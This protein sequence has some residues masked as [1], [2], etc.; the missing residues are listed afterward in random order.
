MIL[1]I[2]VGERQQHQNWFLL[3]FRSRLTFCLSCLKQ[4]S[5]YFFATGRKF[6][7]AF[8]VMFST[9][10]GE[11][12]EMFTAVRLMALNIPSWPR[13]MTLHTHSFLSIFSKLQSR[14]TLESV[15]QY[16]GRCDW[17]Y[18]CFRDWRADTDPQPK[19]NHT[20][21][22]DV[23]RLKDLHLYRI[24]VWSIKSYKKTENSSFFM[25]LWYW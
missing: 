15:W 20:N 14:P 17:G 18:T 7:F 25:C 4:R 11:V 2:A 5:I 16:S 12:A 8:Y 19:W 3:H 9:C 10:R 13:S 22:M 23:P 24:W 21:H 6:L 1:H